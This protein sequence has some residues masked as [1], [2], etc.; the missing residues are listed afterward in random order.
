V[1]VFGNFLPFVENIVGGHLTTIENCPY[2]V[3]VLQDEKLWCG[4]SIIARN[5]VLLAGH[6]VFI[7]I[8]P[9]TVH[10]GTSYHHVD[11]NVTYKPSI[12]LT[13]DVAILHVIEP[14]RY[15]ATRQPI[16]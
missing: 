12:S 16:P 4:G 5:F 7:A 15:D 3:A 10:A 9:L 14:F 8:S 6:C 1:H 13:A 11:Y 2:Q